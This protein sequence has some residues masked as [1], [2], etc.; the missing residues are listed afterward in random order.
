[1]VGIMTPIRGRVPY[2]DN[3]Q[4]SEIE[5]A[6][7]DFDPEPL[8]LA[9]E[10]DLHIF[11]RPQGVTAKQLKEKGIAHPPGA[12]RLLNGDAGFVRSILLKIHGDTCCNCGAGKTVADHIVAV[13]NGGGA[14][15][16]NNYQLL[17]GNC[18]VTKT[19]LDSNKSL[20]KHNTQKP[21]TT[22]KVERIELKVS[23]EFKAALTQAATEDKRSISNFLVCA[24]Q[25]RMHKDY[26]KWYKS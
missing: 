7:L 21:T 6:I 16:L 20:K 25:E 1:M 11:Y 13:C 8:Y 26:I 18:H 17:C 15:W 9:I 5:K 19:R 24:A 10:T 12:V 2:T 14:C 22:V 3:G 23:P 4:F